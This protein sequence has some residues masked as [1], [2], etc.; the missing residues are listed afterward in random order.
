MRTDGGEHGPIREARR[1]NKRSDCPARAV[2]RRRD[3]DSS[4][5]PRQKIQPVQPGGWTRSTFNCPS[6]WTLGCRVQF[7]NRAC[8]IS[9]HPGSMLHP[10]WAGPTSAP[11]YIPGRPVISHYG[12][13]AS[14]RSKSSCAIDSGGSLA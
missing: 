11:A 13:V 14:E 6:T 5:I 10:G 2:I 3:Q 12:S 7:S 8:S 1:K 9:Y 4:Y